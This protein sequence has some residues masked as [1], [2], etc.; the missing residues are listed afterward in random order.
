M[1]H[2]DYFAIIHKY[3]PPDSK[4][5][6]VYIPHV[7]L[8]TAQALSIAK[9]LCLSAEQQR[10]IEEAAM[11][12]DIGIVKVKPYA[13]GT[14]ESVPPYL[15]HG[16]LGRALLE[17][18]GL[19]RHALVAERHIGLGLSRDEILQQRL[20][21]PRRNMLAES[22][23]ERIICWADL[24]FSKSPHL[25]WVQKSVS[26]VRKLASRYGERQLDVF[27]SW[28]NEFGAENGQIGITTS[29]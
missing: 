8:V 13:A 4:L 9:R 14:D 21:L 27:E 19:N 11:L 10:F 26:D 17:S 23:E 6:R 29:P 3:I 2:I 1:Q 25:L 12:H 15:C 16:P 5:Y 22:L 28:L 7:T 18:E 24:F 20:P